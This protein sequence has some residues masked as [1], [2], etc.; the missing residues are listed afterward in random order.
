MIASHLKQ[1]ILRSQKKALARAYVPLTHFKGGERQDPT[2]VA[3]VGGFCAGGTQPR[4]WIE[5]VEGIPRNCTSRQSFG[6]DDEKRNGAAVGE[7]GLQ[8][9]HLLGARIVANQFPSQLLKPRRP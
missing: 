6:P 9:A 3:F 5:Q 8:S 4:R 7:E 2:S 1:H